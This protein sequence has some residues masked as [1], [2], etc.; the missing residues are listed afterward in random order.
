MTDIDIDFIDPTAALVGL[1]H[2]AAVMRQSDGRARH[3]SGVYFQDIP[4]DP[5][6]G[7]AVWDHKEA[8]SVGFFKVD[9]L[10]NKIYLGVR[11]AAHLNFLLTIEPPWEVFNDRD[12]VANLAHIG[13]HFDIVH[14]VQP[15]SIE[16]LAVCLAL[17][18]P[19]KRHLI[20]R[21]RDEIDGEIWMKTDK[22]YFKKSHAI[23]YATAI[24]V[25]LNL[26]VEDVLDGY[27]AGD[28]V[29]TC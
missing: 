15:K 20:N 29:A 17:I 19:G 24:V 6:D 23:S 25:Q 10:V 28:D 8:A 14:A 7:M 21:S 9:F 1:Q 5:L 12:I 22:F 3:A 4:T 16:D 27:R 18:R 2:V 11:D 26:L 13:M